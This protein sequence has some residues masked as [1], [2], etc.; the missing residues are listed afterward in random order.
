[1]KLKVES[2]SLFCSIMVFSPIAMCKYVVLKLYT[3]YCSTKKYVKLFNLINN[4]LKIKRSKVKII[5]D[6]YFYS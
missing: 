5:K 3:E 2:D 1:M 6:N 4:L